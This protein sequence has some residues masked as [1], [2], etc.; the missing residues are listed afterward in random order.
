MATSTNAELL[1]L[2]GKRTFPGKLGVVQEGAYA[3]L[4]LVDVIGLKGKNRSSAR[5]R[6]AHHLAQTST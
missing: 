5:L 3:D 4:L 2:S 6:A 1:T